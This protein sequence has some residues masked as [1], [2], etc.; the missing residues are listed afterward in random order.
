MYRMLDRFP[1][2]PVTSERNDGERVRCVLGT[3]SVSDDPEHEQ[4]TLYATNRFRKAWARHAPRPVVWQR[5]RTAHC[6]LPGKELRSAGPASHR[7]SHAT[8]IIVVTHQAD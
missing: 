1:R 8:I 3:V 7:T 2:A 6:A 5:S 4:T